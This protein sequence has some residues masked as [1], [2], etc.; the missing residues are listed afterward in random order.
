MGEGCQARG[1][2]YVWLLASFRATLL[3]PEAPIIT[4][5]P[6]AELGA[7]LETCY[8]YSRSDVNTCGFKDELELISWSR[9]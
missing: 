3:Y 1:Y 9:G 6:P 8:T 5:S 7:A 2:V 4:F